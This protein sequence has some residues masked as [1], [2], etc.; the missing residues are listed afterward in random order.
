MTPEQTLT[1]V[2]ILLSIAGLVWFFYGPWQRLMVD[3]V[4]Q[5]LFE[6]RDTIFLMAAD[7]EISFESS[8]YQQI[9]TQYN[10]LIRY[11]HEFR[12]THVLAVALSG[13]N[14]P[15]KSVPAIDSINKIRDAE[16]R[17]KLAKKWE[18]TLEHLAILF[19]LRSPLLMLL[20]M[21]IL[22]I[23]VLI[24]ILNRGFVPTMRKSVRT[25]V[26]REYQFDIRVQDRELVIA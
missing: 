10:A 26:E 7:G 19:W 17:A 16:T 18:H 20:T 8:E 25:A 23:L 3:S 22:P 9:R 13:F 12:W 21:V 11:S 1:A 4:R 15:K 24:A 6:T 5:K 2:R 14:P